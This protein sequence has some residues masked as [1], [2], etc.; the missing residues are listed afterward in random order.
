MKARFHSRHGNQ[1]YNGVFLGWNWHADKPDSPSAPNYSIHLPSAITSPLL[2][3]SVAVTADDAPG[4]EEDDKD[5]TTSFSVEAVSANGAA[6]RVVS[7]SFMPL[8]PPL[9]VQFTK[10]ERWMKSFSEVPPS[11]FFRPLRFL[12]AHLCKPIQ[13]LI[14]IKS[15]VFA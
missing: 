11:Q 2:T 9:H 13:P 8:L 12:S 6:A 15:G 7:A 10:L 14:H 3:L 5:G 1:D 4:D